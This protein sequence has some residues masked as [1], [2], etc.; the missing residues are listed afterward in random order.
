MA[1]DDIPTALSEQPSR[2]K[3]Q[4]CRLTVTYTMH[5]TLESL[6]TYIMVGIAFK[7]FVSE[8]PY[9]IEETAIAPHVTGSRVLFVRNSLW[10]RPLDWYFATVRHIVVVLFKITRHPK[11][12]NLGDYN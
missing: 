11:I 3:Q 1:V 8:A 2:V 9:L 6:L 7:G 12:R 4:A 10:S 5:G